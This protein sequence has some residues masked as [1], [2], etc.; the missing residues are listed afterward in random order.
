MSETQIDWGV[1]EALQTEVETLRTQVAHL[2]NDNE[3]LHLDRA[4]HITQIHNLQAGNLTLMRERDEAR[5]ERDRLVE[6]AEL[7]ETT[8][9]RLDKH[10]S[11]VGT[12]DVLLHAIAEA[13]GK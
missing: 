1:V 13:K 2:Q 12:L 9:R 10:G 4:D 6:A 8:I 11:A 7:A 3:Q 5:G